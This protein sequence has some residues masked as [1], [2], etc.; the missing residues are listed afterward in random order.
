MNRPASF[1]KG[2]RRNLA[3]HKN[4][5]PDQERLYRMDI[6][7]MIQ[8]IRHEGWAFILICTYLFFEYVRPQSIW[9]WLDFLPWVPVLLAGAFVGLLAEQ[10]KRPAPHVLNKLMVAY[11]GVVLLSSLFSQYPAV[12]FDRLWTFYNW[13][14]IY[15]L[16]VKI[17]T[18]PARFFI[19]FLSFMV[20]SLKM[21]QH[22][23]ISWAQ[24][25]FSFASWGVT[26]APG[27]FQNS[28]EVG[29]QMCI[30]V[31]M[32]AALVIGLR[33]YWRPL[34]Q[35]VFFSMPLTG[36]GTIV[37]SSSRG[38]MLGLAA[39]GV[40]ALAKTR[41]FTRTLIAVTLIGLVVWQVVPEGF[42]ARFDTAGEDRTSLHRIERWEDGWKT[43][44]EFPLLGVGHN[45]W[46]PYYASHF[47]PKYEGSRMVHNV[48]IQCGTELGYAGLFLLGLLI[49][50]SLKTTREIRRQA[51][52]I[53]ER[54]YYFMSFGF[55]LGLVGL[56]ISAS[57]VTVL[58]YPYLWIYFAL[59]ASMQVSFQNGIKSGA[60]KAN[61]KDA[62]D[63]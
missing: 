61:P 21:S 46:E 37:A 6:K 12:S 27:F 63:S 16:I 22:G 15:F 25:G 23:F 48:F 18:T 9:T 10:K 20:Y 19:F 47:T 43:L 32:A 34:W 42:K 44:N 4:T 57:F 33:R 3:G 45:A 51:K 14:I 31:P 41:Y 59:V 62:Q 2:G 17:I 30:Y 50:Y 36:I 13:L 55:D 7:Y 28:G 54:F 8:T 38:A 39:S 24:R 58:Y 40:M 26:G 35:I 29:I 5:P 52:E 49:F 1:A 11:F 60:L 53:N 56:L